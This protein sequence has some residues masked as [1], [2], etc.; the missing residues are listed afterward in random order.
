V[1]FTIRYSI[2]LSQDKS[3]KTTWQLAAVGRYIQVVEKVWGWDKDVKLHPVEFLLYHESGGK[4]ASH[5]AAQ[6]GSEKLIRKNC[7]VG[8]KKRYQALIC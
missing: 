8:L 2:L 1:T 5:V 6:M 4:T 7:E 3:N